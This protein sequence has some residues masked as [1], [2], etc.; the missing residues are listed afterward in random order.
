MMVEMGV[1]EEERTRRGK[2]MGEQDCT[3]FENIYV[4]DKTL[5]IV[6]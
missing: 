6:R 2:E 4:S 5:A 3:D 1:S